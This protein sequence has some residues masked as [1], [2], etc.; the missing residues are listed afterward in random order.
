MEVV[1]LATSEEIAL[2]ETRIAY[3]NCGLLDRSVSRIGRQGAAYVGHFAELAAAV[4]V[5]V[6][7]ITACI[8]E[9]ALSHMQLASQGGG[10]VATPITWLGQH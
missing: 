9:H 8:D 7:L 1:P 4:V 2:S 6:S 5:D 10:R 3:D